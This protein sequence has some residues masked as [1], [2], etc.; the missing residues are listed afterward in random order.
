MKRLFAC[1]LL[2]LAVIGYAKADQSTFEETN[3]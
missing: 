1:T 3:Q 2:T